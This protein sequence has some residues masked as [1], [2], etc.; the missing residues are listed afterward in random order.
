MRL[1]QRL[2]NVENYLYATLNRRSRKVENANW[3]DVTFLT[4]KNVDI[5]LSI[6]STKSQRQTDV[7]TTSKFQVESTNT[8][9]TSFRR[10]DANVEPTF[11]KRRQNNVDITLLTLSTYFQPNFDVE[12]TSYARWVLIGLTQIKLIAISKLNF[13]FISSQVHI[14]NCKTFETFL[15]RWKNHYPVH[16]TI[17]HS[18]NRPE[19]FERLLPKSIVYVELYFTSQSDCLIYQGLHLYYMSIY[20]SANTIQW[21]L[22][23]IPLDFLRAMVLDFI[24]SGRSCPAYHQRLLAL[25]QDGSI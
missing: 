19:F 9:S 4:L 13:P 10:L 25:S 12:T 23:I 5:T 18:N 16:S 6:S 3:I 7:E 17:Q 1:F 2:T 24:I 8:V 20:F 22:N 11:A 14:C 15:L 21:E